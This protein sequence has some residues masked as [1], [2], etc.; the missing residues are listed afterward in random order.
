MWPN[1]A[2]DFTP[3]LAKTESIELLSNAIGLDI[4]DDKALFHRFESSRDEIEVECGFVLDWRELPEKEPT[5]L[6]C[7]RTLTSRTR[8]SGQNSSIGLW[9]GCLE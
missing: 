4:A 9:I 8:L 6:S 3:R 2:T 7:C 5:V 1:G